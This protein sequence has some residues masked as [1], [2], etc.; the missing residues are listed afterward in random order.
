MYKRMPH[1]TI[2]RFYKINSAGQKGVTQYVQHAKRKKHK[3]RMLCLK[4]LFRT[5]GDSKFSSQAKAKGVHHH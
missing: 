5:E 3:E 2:S 1:R 4:K